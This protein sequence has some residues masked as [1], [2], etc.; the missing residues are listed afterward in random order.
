MKNVVIKSV[1]DDQEG[2]LSEMSSTNV[3]DIQGLSCTMLIVKTKNAMD[4][5]QAGETLEVHSTDKGSINDLKAWCKAVGHEI[6]DIK[7]EDNLIKFWIK[8]HA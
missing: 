5:L 4:Q 2:G 1:N 7:E 6:M 8:K 3:L